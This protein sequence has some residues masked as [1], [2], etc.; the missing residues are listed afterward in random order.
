MGP[1]TVSPPPRCT[2]GTRYSSI[3]HTQKRK[4][5]FWKIY[6]P[7]LVH[8]C[9]FSAEFVEISFFLNQY[10][11]ESMIFQFVLISKSTVLF[12]DSHFDRYLRFNLLLVKN[13][14]IH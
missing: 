13:L 1:L 9:N 4:Q 11:L 6:L 3:S 10:L 14:S 12:F 8:I 7:I 2:R 5:S